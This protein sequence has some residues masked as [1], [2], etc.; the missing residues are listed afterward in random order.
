MD[1]AVSHLRTGTRRWQIRASRGK[2]QNQNLDYIITGQDPWKHF[3]HRYWKEAGNEHRLTDP[4]LP[5]QVQLKG[6]F[7]CTFVFKELHWCFVM[8]TA[9]GQHPSWVKPLFLPLSWILHGATDL[10]QK[11]PQV[12]FHANHPVWV[13]YAILGSRWTL[14]L[15]HSQHS[16]TGL[17]LQQLWLYELVCREKEAPPHKARRTLPLI[18]F[19]LKRDTRD[20][21]FGVNGTGSHRTY[22]NWGT[23]DILTPPPA[24]CK[25]LG[26]KDINFAFIGT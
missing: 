18:V 4:P 26:G 25:I 8:P 17:D 23:F 1:R 16:Y 6:L 14:S 22:R 7:I 15:P 10:V 12:G 24:H 13:R 3:Q 2:G 21:E 5:T 19:C 9:R 20:T 11:N